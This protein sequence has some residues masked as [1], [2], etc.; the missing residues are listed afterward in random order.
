M[1]FRNFTANKLDLV[2]LPGLSG[3][4]RDHGVMLTYRKMFYIY[5]YFSLFPFRISFASFFLLALAL[6]ITEEYK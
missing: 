4:L 5:I 3:D 1:S 2:A 6:L